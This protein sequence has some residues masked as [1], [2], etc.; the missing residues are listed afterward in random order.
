MFSKLAQST[1]PPANYIIQG[2]EYNMVYYLAD[3]I[4]SNWSTIVQTISD[5]QGPKKF[6]FAARQKAC[7]KDVECAFGVLQSMIAIIKDD[8]AFGRNKYCMTTCIIMSNMIIEG[9]RDINAPIRDAREV[10]VLQL[11]MAINKNTRFQQFLARDLQIKNK[12]AHLSLRNALIDPYMGE[13]W[14]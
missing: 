8:V 4:Y 3:G 6:F 5:P 11:E 12:E 1:P 14:E 9:E 7:R 10:P 2:Q 13:L